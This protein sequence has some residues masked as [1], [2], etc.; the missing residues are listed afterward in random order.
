MKLTIIILALVVVASVAF[1]I[2]SRKRGPQADAEAAVARGEYQFIALL[3]PEGKWTRPQ[4]PEIPAWYFETGCIR[5]RETKPETR[6]ADV[7]YMTSYN[8]ALYR[9][10]RMQGKFHIIKENVAEVKANLDR[11][12]QSKQSK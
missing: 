7:A 4:V 9:A 11:Y 1:L 8:D 5:I 10:L 3:D 6:E 2:L 12:E